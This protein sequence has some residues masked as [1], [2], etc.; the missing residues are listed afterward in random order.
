MISTN[1]IVFNLRSSALLFLAP[2]IRRITRKFTILKK[3]TMCIN[4]N[5]YFK[6]LN[7]RSEHSPFFEYFMDLFLLKGMKTYLSLSILCI[8]QKYMKQFQQYENVH[9]AHSNVI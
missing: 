8:K 3:M 6:C 7:P 4:M 5:N 9:V 2:S 1:K